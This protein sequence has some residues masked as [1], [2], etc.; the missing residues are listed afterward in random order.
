MQGNLLSRCEVLLIKASPILDIS[1]VI[2]KVECVSRIIVVWVANE[3][4]E[5]LIVCIPAFEG[6]PAITAVDL[7]GPIGRSVF[8]FVPEEESLCE[9][10]YGP[11]GTFL[12]EP[13]ASILKAG[14]FKLFA[15]SY[16]LIKLH[17]NTPLY[18]RAR[19]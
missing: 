15:R 2:R 3:V 9:I 17:A 10:D 11:V 14:A 4:K 8:A 13:H 1:S 19:R 16:G 12:Y 7:A 6:S 18:W 5:L